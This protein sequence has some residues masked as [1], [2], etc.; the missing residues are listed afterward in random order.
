[1]K[2]LK[3]FTTGLILVAGLLAVAGPAAAGPILVANS[4]VA[5]DQVAPPQVQKI[6]LGKTAQWEDGTRI[7]LAVL[8]SGPVTDAFMKNYVKKSPK[9]F[10]TFWKKAVFSGTGEMPAMFDTEA[11]LV[12]F[13]AKTPGAV[14]FVDDASPHD[15]VKVLAVQ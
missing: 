10:S 2:T 4:G 5:A 9:Q 13:V 14:G 15:G 1:M 3:T 8:K 6:F 7:V 11:E 12:A